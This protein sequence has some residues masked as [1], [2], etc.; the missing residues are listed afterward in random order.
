VSAALSTQLR[1]EVA[2]MATMFLFVAG[3]F[4]DYVVSLATG[5][6]EG[7]GPTQAMLRMFRGV[8][9]PT[10]PL[11]ASPGRTLAEGV[12]V[13]Y[14]RLFGFLRMIIPDVRTYD[15]SEYVA[16]GFNVALLDPGGDDLILKT[17]LLL[18]YL[19][20]WAFVAYYLLRWREVA[21]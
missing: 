15:L 19:L 18:G 4:P 7:G 20:P 14:Q 16:K 2:F 17:I 11:E 8:P 10:I 1:G 13:L 9:S 12:D 21:A 3:M 5:Q 6:V